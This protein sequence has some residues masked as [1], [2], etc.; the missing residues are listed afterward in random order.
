MSL[1][2][3]SSGRPSPTRAL[4]RPRFLPLS[5][6]PPVA[7]RQELVA[8]AESG[9]VPGYAPSSLAQL[10]ATAGALGLCLHGVGA[11][12]ASSEPGLGAC[13]RPGLAPPLPAGQA[14]GCGR[15]GRR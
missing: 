12:G 5:P 4:S 13:L 1:A 7:W 8:L 6:A 15:V 3:P 10:Q 2:S 9:A 14:L 11:E